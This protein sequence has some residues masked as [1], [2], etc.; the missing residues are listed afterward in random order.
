ML[1]KNPVAPHTCLI[2]VDEETGCER[3][4]VLQLVEKAM[5]FQHMTGD[6]DIKSNRETLVRAPA[7]LEENVKASSRCDCRRRI[8]LEVSRN[9]VHVQEVLV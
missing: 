6:A 3:R 1:H 7:I 9:L 2:H 4:L 8:G 5:R